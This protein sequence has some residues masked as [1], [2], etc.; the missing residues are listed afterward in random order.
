MHPEHVG[1]F[2]A[3][4]YWLAGR[5]MADL[6]LGPL[7]LW[8]WA[9]IGK[10]LELV[11][12]LSFVI[13]IIGEQRFRNLSR[14]VRERFAPRLIV[15]ASAEIISL[16]PPLL[17]YTFWLL[18]ELPLVS[19]QGSTR[20][21][22]QA[23]HPAALAR[24][25]WNSLRADSPTPRT[26]AAQAKFN[27]C[28]R[29]RRRS[30]LWRMLALLFVLPGVLFLALAAWPSHAGVASI[31]AFVVVLLLG[32]FLLYLASFPLALCF[33]L[34]ALA[35]NVLVVQ[36]FAAVAGREHLKA[37]WLAVSALLLVLGFHFDLLAS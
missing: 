24:S 33:S 34:L 15:Q 22:F 29:N 3:W 35:V 31:W 5:H 4:R 25:W 11:G 12:G 8:W 23:G 19:L 9:R 26:D 21:T 18:T 14:S 1:L 37:E 36:P 13:D 7:P 27:A 16:L 20:L 2:E 28:L 6:I 30:A 32:S 10:C 17:A